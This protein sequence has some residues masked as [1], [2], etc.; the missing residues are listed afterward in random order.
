MG[1]GNLI[2]I[3]THSNYDNINDELNVRLNRFYKTL[4]LFA[5][6]VN[7]EKATLSEG[8]HV[9]AIF[10]VP[11]Y[12]FSGPGKTPISALDHDN[13]LRQL[14]QL[15]SC[16]PNLLI[17]PGTIYYSRDL[18]D[19]KERLKWLRDLTKAKQTAREINRGYV[20]NQDMILGQN[21]QVVPKL[22][23]VSVNVMTGKP[24]RIFNNAY[25]LRNGQILFFYEK[26]ADFLEARGATPDKQ[27]F[28]P[29]NRS[30]DAQTWGSQF[31][32]KFGMEICFD[33]AEG[34]LRRR[35]IPG[36][37]YHIVVSDWAKTATGNFAMEDKGYFIHAST[38]Y[39][40]SSIYYNSKGTMINLTTDKK[41][42]KYH[43]VLGGGGY[44]DYYSIMPPPLIK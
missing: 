2:G 8:N 37:N 27:V 31:P 29:G 15:S 39:S 40:E 7:K 32:L 24:I 38:N 5:S 19:E 9:Q 18:Y 36:L 25:M 22:N 16:Y 3:W 30:G 26:T 21:K 20:I 10:V 41:Y 23:Q 33:H 35:N 14:M 1:N 43:S 42:W 17:V 12:Y 44:L 13:V 34:I 28:I 11:E 6:V 4:N